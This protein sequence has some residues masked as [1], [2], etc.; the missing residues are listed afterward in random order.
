MDPVSQFPSRDNHN[1][2]YK[3]QNVNNKLDDATQKEMRRRREK[4]KNTEKWF[5]DT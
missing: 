3:P 4:K 2:R 5:G 1:K